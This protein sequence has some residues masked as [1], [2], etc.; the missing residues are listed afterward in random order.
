MDLLSSLTNVDLTAL[1]L[2]IDFLGFRNNANLC[3]ISAGEEIEN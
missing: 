3:D 2:A 1:Y